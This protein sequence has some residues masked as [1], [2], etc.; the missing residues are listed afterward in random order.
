METRVIDGVEL[1]VTSYQA[2]GGVATV[3]LRR[4]PGN[5][6][7]GRMHHEYR[8]CLAE[9][10]SDPSVRAI[11]V[12]GAGRAF[13]VGA[14]AKA[15][16]HQVGRDSYDPGVDPAELPRPGYGTHVEF[17]ELFAYHF[18]L[19]KPVIAAVNGPAAGVGLVLACFADIR[20][21]AAGAKLTVATPKLGLPAEF[22]LSW[23]LPRIVGLGRAAD[24]L[25]TSRIVLAEEA[26]TMGLVN[27]VVPG[28][29][30]LDAATAYA[31]Q[32][33]TT[34]SPAA[35]REVKRQLYTDLHR[36]VGA[37]VR[38]A[39]TSV[40]TLITGPDFAEGVAA[41]RER[42]PPQFPG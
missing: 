22:G 25:M 38:D 2:T 16:D 18:G 19:L 3:T 7:T 9:A 20:F 6:W 23:I 39:G 36:G 30:L 10:E 11:V 37:S 17:D 4:P 26:A 31:T 8:A 32:L 34:V 5:S 28:D 12:T 33:A 29:E 14:D 24:L 13:C 15:L 1:K 35:L 40:G 27:Q 42:R 41:W 21:A